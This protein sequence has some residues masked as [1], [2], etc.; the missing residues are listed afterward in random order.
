[1]GMATS[2]SVSGQKVLIT[3][4]SR[5]I[6]RALALAFSGGGA[7]VIAAARDTRKLEN[8]QQEI[9]ATGGECTVVSMD[10]ADLQS[11]T[12]AFRFIEGEFGALDVLVNNA[13]VER[14]KG[15]L[16]VDEATW[17]AIVDVNLKGAFFCAQGAAKLMLGKGGSILNLC[18]LTSAV[19]VPGAVPY[20][21]SKSG[22][23]GMTRGLATEWAP[24]GIR[25]NA[26]GPGYFETDMTQVFY[27]DPQWQN[28]MRQKVPLG[29]LGRLDDLSGAAIF[30]SSAA[31]SYITGQV[32]YVD[33]G[34]LAGI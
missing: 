6:G 30:L 4:A 1:M 29:R 19:G 33:G 32:L 2:F 3:G 31:A 24:L 26:I 17:D 28:T 9:V 16:E 27:D 11:I 14:L 18:S 12:A 13:G 34:Y 15:S 22:L 25:V 5:G 20:G 8:L 23:L 10:V 21:S 7:A